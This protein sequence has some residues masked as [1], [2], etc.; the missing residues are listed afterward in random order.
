MEEAS[1]ATWQAL[2]YHHAEKSRD[3]YWG[4]GLISITVAIIS[5]I[6][7]NVLFGIFVL[8]AS[9]T[10]AIFAHRPP[11]TITIHMGTA[12]I[13]VEKTLYV[14]KD[15]ESFWI[16]LEENPAHPKILFKSKKFFMPYI[17]VPLG[18]AHPDDV[19]D[20]LAQFLPEVEHKEPLLQRL[21]EDVGL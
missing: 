19:G 16:E 17:I 3:W 7:G 10:L 11:R 14:Y 12:G 21:L 2:E 18:D 6:L 13:L 15:M 9:V 5:F 20:F 4:L 1:A 8:L